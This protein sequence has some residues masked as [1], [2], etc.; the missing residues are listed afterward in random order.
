MNETRL[1]KRG[2]AKG[3]G[4]NN[5]PILTAVNGP[6]RKVPTPAPG[7]HALKVTKERQ[8]ATIQTK[9][10]HNSRKN[11]ISPFRNPRKT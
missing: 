9:K 7:E 2:K 8:E 3:L 5:F 6:R 10:T 1:D 11:G 4:Q